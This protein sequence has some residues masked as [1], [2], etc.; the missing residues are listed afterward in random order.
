MN[1]KILNALWLFLMLASFSVAHAQVKQCPLDLSVTQYQEKADAG[2]MPI[3]DAEATATNTITK[4]VTKAVLFEGMPRFANLPE[5]RYDLTVTKAG[6]ART[7][8]RIKIDCRGLA[9][10]GSLSEDVFLWKGSPEQT[11]RMRNVSI[12]LKSKDNVPIES[13]VVETPKPVSLGSKSIS[14][15]VLN[16]K[17][18]KLVTPD[19]PAAA[20][21]VRATGTVNVQVTIDEQGNVISAS[22]VSGHPL[23]RQAAVE[24]ARASSFAPT[25]LS[26]QPVKVTGIIVYTFAP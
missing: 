18:T 10:D 13:S 24:A 20:R 16:E 7:L 21:A 5:G 11:M 4:K 14:G 2:V 15:A 22:A 8:K 1:F 3:S 6:Y 25:L 9:D 26:G 23:L 17:A 19:Y 12:A